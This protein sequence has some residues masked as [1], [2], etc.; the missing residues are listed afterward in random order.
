MAAVRVRITDPLHVP[1]FDA[2][3]DYQEE[4]HQIFGPV[5]L[6]YSTPLP[7]GFAMTQGLLHLHH[8]LRSFRASSYVIRPPLP[9]PL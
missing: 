1:L 8:L 9:T 6:T 5:I 2:I 4:E 3:M 7:A